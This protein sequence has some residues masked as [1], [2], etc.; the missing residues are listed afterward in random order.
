MNHAYFDY[1]AEK[2]KEHQFERHAGI[3]IYIYLWLISNYVFL[4][5]QKEMRDDL[6]LKQVSNN[7]LQMESLWLLV[8]LDSLSW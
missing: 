4:V 7:A 2:L 1:K 6:R 8:P 5:N 3:K